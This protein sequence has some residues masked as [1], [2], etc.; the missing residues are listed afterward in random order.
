[1]SVQVRPAEESDIRAMAALRAHERETEAFWQTSIRRYL[2]GERSP[3]QALLPRA[4]FVAEDKGVV[5][6]F[7][8]CHRTTRYGC[9]GELQW[10]NV[11]PEYRGRGV[12]GKLL[13]KMASW[14]VEQDSL[15]V[16]VDVDPQNSAARAL[17]RKHGAQP[18]KEHWM[19]WKDI[20]SILSAGENPDE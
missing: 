1:M 17:Y 3:R 8:A 18:L 16:C 19:V 12:A 13:K 9:R 14:F 11:A 20:R 5:M 4:A 2:S 10:I 15:R 6:G 7:V